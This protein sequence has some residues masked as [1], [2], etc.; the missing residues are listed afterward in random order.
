MSE[1][2]VNKI[3]PR[4]NCGTTQLGDAGDTI[5]VTGDLKSNSL[6]SASGSTITLGQ[7]GDTIQLG[8]GA[9]QT[10]FGRTGT[11]DWDTTAKTA[12]FTAV[13]GN[14]Y[15]VNTTSGAITVT[16]PASPSAGDIVSLS[17]YA[18]TWGTNNVTL[19]SANYN[20]QTGTPSLSTNSQTVTL[21]Y[22]DGTKGWITTNSDTD[23]VS[24]FVPVVATGGTV[25]TCGDYKIHTFTSPG[26]FCV[27]CAGAGTVDYMVVAGGGG[28][29]GSATQYYSAGGGGAGGWRASSGT[30]SGCYTAGPGPLTACVSALPITATGYPITVG[31]GGAG[32]GGSLSPDPPGS[33]GRGSSGNNSVF[34]TITSNGGGAGGKSGSNPAPSAGCGA[35]GDGASGG[36]GGGYG[37]S[38]GGVG[39][40]PPT[41]PPQGNSGGTGDGS[42][43]GYGGAGGG[44]TATGEPSDIQPTH[45]A[46]GGAGATS[47]ITFSPTTYAA[48]GPAGIDKCSPANAGGS[49]T[50]DGGAGGSDNPGCAS[51]GSGGSGIVVI[52]Y[53]YQ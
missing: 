42:S 47:C 28:G 48:G 9:T 5:T 40:T 29:G 25:T 41:N 50:G 20:G 11:V 6:K 8:C 43:R 37:S 3:S 52:R 39:N 17:D 24:G 19:S 4:T 32:G 1:V 45:G 53:K 22:V 44:A 51:G 2:K 14:G 13:S 7:S 26:T 27:S 31:A 33:R 36:G 35:G 49:N 18:G 30:A 23:R 15:F 34:S 21:I 38:G 46:L 16:M 10:G 12:S